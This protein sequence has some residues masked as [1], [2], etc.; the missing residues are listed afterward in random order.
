MACVR[1]KTPWLECIQNLF[2]FSILNFNPYQA[3][4]AKHLPLALL[5]SCEY[6]LDYSSIHYCLLV[7]VYFASSL[8]TLYVS[9]SAK[10]GH[11][12]RCVD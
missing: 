5:F 8:S 3:G 6:G 10:T 12:P 7:L 9:R 2:E 11:F 4:F 1:K